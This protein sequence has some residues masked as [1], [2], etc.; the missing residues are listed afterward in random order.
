MRLDLKAI[1]IIKKV[2]NKWCVFSESS[3]RNLGC[4]PTKDGAIERLRQVEYFK[5]SKGTIVNEMPLGVD[6]SGGILYEFADNSIYAI[7][8]VGIY[9]LKDDTLEIEADAGQD[10]PEIYWV[11]KN[12]WTSAGPDGHMHIVVVDDKGD[13]FTTFDTNTGAEHVHRHEIKSWKVVESDGH[14]HLI[15]GMNHEHSDASHSFEVYAFEDQ[16]ASG[17]LYLFDNLIAIEKPI[18]N[19]VLGIYNELVEAQK[20]KRS[21]YNKLKRKV[22]M[23]A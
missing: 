14:M 1:A 8:S 5:K 18:S 12:V 22:K 4:A 20:D 19:L 17:E 10:I 11:L 7:D 13:G 2:G 23:S 16:D 3:N 15:N 6:D 21:P 9:K